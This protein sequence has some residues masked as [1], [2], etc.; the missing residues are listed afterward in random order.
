[1]TR[2]N[3]DLIMSL[4]TEKEWELSIEEEEQLRKSDEY[5]EVQEILAAYAEEHERF[6]N[7]NSED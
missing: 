4:E 5:Y 1:M 2:Q 6:L 7:E 3:V